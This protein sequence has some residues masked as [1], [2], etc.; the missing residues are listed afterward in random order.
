MR[1]GFGGW[2]VGGLGGLFSLNSLNSP[3]LRREDSPS[4]EQGAELEDECGDHPGEAYGVGH[5]EE[6]P[7]PAAALVLDGYDGGETGHVEQDEEEHGHGGER[8]AVAMGV[9]AVQQ[10]MKN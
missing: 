3:T 7:A 6:G 1:I 10:F 4:E 8:C 9:T 5:G 2:V